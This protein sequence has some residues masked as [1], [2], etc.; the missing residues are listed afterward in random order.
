MKILITLSYYTPNVSGLTY[1]AKVVAEELVRKKHQVEVIASNYLKTFSKYKKE[2]GVLVKSI[3]T[4]ILLGRGPIMPTYFVESFF[5]VKNADAVNCHLPQFEAIFPIMWAKM[6]GK[7]VLITYHCDL[8]N[9]GGL[10]NQLTEKV[11]LISHFIA[12]SLA[13]VIWV[14]TKDY[15][16]S[17]KMLQHFK[18]KLV[19][20]YP[21][22][23][24]MKS[25]K[26]PISKWKNVKYKIG[27]VGRIAKEKGMNYLLESKNYLKK[28]LGSNFKIFI[29]GPSSDV[30]G[31][32]E[33]ELND[34]LIKYKNEIVVLG[35]LSDDDLFGFY[36]NIDVLVLPSTQSLESFGTVQVEAMLSGCPVVASDLPGVRVPVEITKMGEVVPV[37][38]SIAISKAIVKIIKNKT[39][40]LEIHKNLNKLFS[41]EVV[42]NNYEEIYKNL[43]KK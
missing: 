19:Y 36:K 35:K 29:V 38:D 18:R 30:I 27:Y 41:L 16:E 6:L 8:A 5:S 1:H 13:D 10:V 32:G 20:H 43:L 12:C 17:S 34:L 24:F 3:W 40:Y 26:N 11:T 14:S 7:K 25:N 15:A 2:N 39:K 37:K 4:P 33:S 42:I 31:G 22:I 21:P 28:K 23:K 9:W